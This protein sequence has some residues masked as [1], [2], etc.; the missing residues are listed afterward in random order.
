MRRLLII[1][2]VFIGMLT[3]FA[4]DFLASYATTSGQLWLMVPCAVWAGCL[5]WI[6]R[7]ADYDMGPRYRINTVVEEPA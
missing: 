5:V 7:L 1:M 2:L 6:R 4:G 3:A